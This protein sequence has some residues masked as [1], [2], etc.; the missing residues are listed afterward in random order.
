MYRNYH[1]NCCCCTEYNLNNLNHCC[2]F[3]TPSC[4]LNC[5]PCELHCYHA[6]KRLPQSYRKLTTMPP[7]LNTTSETSSG[8]NSAKLKKK[9]KP[10]KGSKNGV[11]SRDSAIEKISLN[12]RIASITSSNSE[13]PRR[14]FPD[15]SNN[16]RLSHSESLVGRRS[17]TGSGNNGIQNSDSYCNYQCVCRPSKGC[18]GKPAINFNLLTHNGMP[19]KQTYPDRGPSYRIS[20]NHIKQNEFNYIAL[21]N[22][23]PPLNSNRISNNSRN[24]YTTQPSYVRQGYNKSPHQSHLSSVSK[25]STRLNCQHSAKKCS[26][27]KNLSCSC[28]CNLCR[29]TSPTGTSS[30]RSSRQSFSSS[31]SCPQLDVINEEEAENEE[32]ANFVS[33]QS[34]RNSTESYTKPESRSKPIVTGTPKIQK[35]LE[36]SCAD[37]LNIVCDNILESVQKSVDS[38]L[39]EYSSN[40][41]QNFESLGQKLE[42]SESAVKSLCMEIMEKMTEQNKNNLVQICSVVQN[43]V[44]NQTAN[45]YAMT[46]NN[47]QDKECQCEPE[48]KEENEFITDVVQDIN[49]G[50]ALKE[51]TTMAAEI[52]LCTCCHCNDTNPSLNEKNPKEV[53]T[54]NAKNDD[55]RMEKST[56]DAK[57]QRCSCCHCNDANSAHTL[58]LYKSYSSSTIEEQIDHPL[59]STEQSGLMQNAHSFGRNEGGR[60][61]DIKLL[62]LPIKYPPQEDS[63]PRSS[64]GRDDLRIVGKPVQFSPSEVASPRKSCVRCMNLNKEEDIPI[65]KLYPPPE[66]ETSSARALNSQHDISPQMFTTFSLTPS[67]KTIFNCNCSK[68]CKY[69]G[70]DNVSVCVK[71]V[72]RNIY[73]NYDTS[74][75][76]TEPEDNND[77]AASNSARKKLQKKASK[78]Q[79]SSQTLMA[80]G[81]EIVN[82]RQISRRTSKTNSSKD[83][84]ASPTR[85][86]RL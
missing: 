24:S 66:E 83:S 56:S 28:N 52:Q 57:P 65:S 64:T 55:G 26:L 60:E 11:Q 7:K 81:Q 29:K 41:V 18:L 54:N 69:D 1:G 3:L 71:S 16:V 49:N 22:L 40:V 73:D 50:N 77:P 51:E 17:S 15:G 74:G 10:K 67:G 4:D 31:K 2:H 84:N 33:N 48:I 86:S 6:T 82:G 35:S 61:D 47:C 58:A 45:Q 70:S 76:A 36:D 78:Q 42:K 9:T 20:S 12:D 75:Y 13:N 79:C 39:Q 37:F 21:E 63:S 19:I 38:K 44:E 23:P 72:C 14:S 85:L 46:R 27:T 68:E 62:T 59:R 43:L 8:K 34:F 25:S 80:I 30:V 5:C 32:Y 53:T